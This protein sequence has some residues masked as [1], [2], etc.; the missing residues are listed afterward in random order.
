MP[1]FPETASQASR[2]RQ[3]TFEGFAEKIREKSK[4]GELIAMH[5]GDSAWA[6]PEVLRTTD[7]NEARLHVYGPVEGWPELRQATV[8]RL[9]R[10]HGI[11][12]T[13][14]QLFICSLWLGRCSFCILYS[15]N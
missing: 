11:V 4:R 10:L 13:P 1:R 7:L 12:C 2:I 8:D 6:P 15:Q 9:S 14:A 3:E 5:L